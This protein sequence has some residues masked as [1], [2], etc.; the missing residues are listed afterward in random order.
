MDKN[1]LSVNRPQEVDP[2]QSRKTLMIN[3]TQKS[4]F[5]K[6][7]ANDKKT[8]PGKFTS[9]VLPKLERLDNDESCNSGASE[10]EDDQYK[11]KNLS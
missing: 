4:Q 9:H 7:S 10:D 2:K 1:K 6:L 11:Q 3:V 8:P 5:V